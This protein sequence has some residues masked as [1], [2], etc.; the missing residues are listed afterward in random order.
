LR[1]ADAQFVP[2]DSEGGRS[3]AHRHIYQR[4][5]WIRHWTV[6]P[7]E[8]KILTYGFHSEFPSSLEISVRRH[9]PSTAGTDIRN[10]FDKGNTVLTNQDHLKRQPLAAGY[11]SFRMLRG[12]TDALAS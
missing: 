6:H 7:E 9:T 5:L 3:A 2:Q 12:R 11:D 8:S 1:Q 10:S 4:M